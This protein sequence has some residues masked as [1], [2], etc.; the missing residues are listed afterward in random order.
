[1][2]VGQRRFDV[3]LKL[4]AGLLFLQNRKPDCSAAKNGAQRKT[5]VVRLDASVL[6]SRFGELE[7]ET[8]ARIALA[9]QKKCDSKRQTSD[10][11]TIEAHYVTR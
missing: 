6:F 9:S 11:Q 3:A 7:F 8:G 4:P 1:M 2:I 5:T 10:A